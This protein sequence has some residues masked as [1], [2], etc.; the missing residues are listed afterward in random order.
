M[1]KYSQPFNS[2]VKRKDSSPRPYRTRHRDG[3]TG[4][5]HVLAALGHKW[6]R[7]SPREAVGILSRTSGSCPKMNDEG[8]FAVLWYSRGQEGKNG[9]PQESKNLM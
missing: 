5:T 8:G 3:N 6:R 1:H 2:A 9:E 4:G 7:C